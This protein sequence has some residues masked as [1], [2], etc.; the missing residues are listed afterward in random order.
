MEANMRRTRLCFLIAAMLAGA[1]LAAAAQ[2]P[3][4]SAPRGYVL[5]LGDSLTFGY[6][7]TKFDA[8]PDPSNFSTGYVDDFARRLTATAPGRDA[9]VVNFGCPGETTS[10][11]LTGPC[12]YH[13]VFGLHLH[14][15]FDGSQIAAAEAF[16]AA[17]PGQVGPI[18]ISLGANDILALVT[19]CGGVNLQCI[20]SQLPSILAAISANYQGAIGRLRT[21]APDAE[22]IAVALY[23]PY[24]VFDA[25]TNAQT[26]GLTALINQGIEAVAAANR[27]RVANPFPA[28]NLTPPQPA[29]LCLLTFFCGNGD[30]H[31]TDPGYQLIADL[32]WTASGYARFEQ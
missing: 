14:D 15:D 4:F 32:I 31:P 20:S 6:Q 24:A 17:H 22:I 27:V 5:A 26:N 10:S 25:A 11:F 18:L 28:F 8:N 23:N 2:Q 1:P 13:A 30:I 9:R 29:R 16:L 21:A 3:V 12:T 19:A 7:Q